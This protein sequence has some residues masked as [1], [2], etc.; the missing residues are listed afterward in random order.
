MVQGSHILSFTDSYIALDWMHKSPFDRVN[1]RTHD[2]VSRWVGWTLVSN[3]T[4]LYS[5]HIKETEN[6][7]GDSLSTDFHRSDQTITLKYQP[8][9]I[10][11][12][13]GI[14]PH[15]TAAQESYLLDI[16]VSGSIDASN[17]IAKAT[18][19]KQYGNWG[20]WAT[21]LKHSGITD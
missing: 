21:F 18:A 3:K 2:A 8:N 5:Q 7:I 1:A 9:T 10:T 16:I 20:S 11:A 17:G 4:S 15:Q 13:R 19:T 12:D 14:V 6:I